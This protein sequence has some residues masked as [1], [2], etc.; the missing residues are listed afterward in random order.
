MLDRWKKED[1]P[2]MKKL[3][4]EVDIPE[5]PVE[6]AMEADA[7]EGQKAIANLTLIAFYFL[8]R[9]GE[10]TYRKRRNE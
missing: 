3:P 8:L 7:D 4:I 9:V 6:R 2:A 5:Y 10:Y 1:P